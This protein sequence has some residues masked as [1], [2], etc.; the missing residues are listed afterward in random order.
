MSEITSK[1]LFSQVVLILKA[2]GLYQ[3]S[4]T[5]VPIVTREAGI[6]EMKRRG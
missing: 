1:K 4:L 6:T 5:S 3:L 2:K